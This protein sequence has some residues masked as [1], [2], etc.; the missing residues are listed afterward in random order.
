VRIPGDPE[1][2]KSFQYIHGLRSFHDLQRFPP[3][4]RVDHFQIDDV[5][6]MQIKIRQRFLQFKSRRRA[7]QDLQYR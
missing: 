3:P 7:A 6:R 4:H 5:G 1:S 2:T